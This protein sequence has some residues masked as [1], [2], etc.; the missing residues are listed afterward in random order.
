MN[1]L[2]TPCMYGFHFF[3]FFRGALKWS[4][5]LISFSSDFWA[6]LSHVCVFA[7]LRDFCSAGSQSWT[8]AVISHIC[9]YL[10]TSSW[11]VSFKRAGDGPV[12]ASPWVWQDGHSAYTA[13]Y[14]SDAWTDFRGSNLFCSALSIL[15]REVQAGTSSEVEAP[16][17]CM[18][19]F[20][21]DS[22][23]IAFACGL[24]RSWLREEAVLAVRHP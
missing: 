14:L 2:K 1:L 24:Q 3:F 20:W 22:D 7:G 8:P 4:D 21:H 23:W 19:Y 11:P 5:L 9:V 13:W 16:W 12:H 18:E 10:V 6:E 15:V 17:S